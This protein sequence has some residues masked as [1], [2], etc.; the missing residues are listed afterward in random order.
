MAK[1]RSKA[2]GR[3][4]RCSGPSVVDYVD[5]SE[6][7]TRPADEHFHIGKFAFRIPFVCGARD[8]GRASVSR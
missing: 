4:P 5:E 1:A 6:V 2:L 8:L 7:L 3:R